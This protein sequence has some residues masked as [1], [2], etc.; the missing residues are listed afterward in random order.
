[1]S[2]TNVYFEWLAKTFAAVTVQQFY[3]KQNM[4]GNDGKQFNHL[5]LLF[6]IIQVGILIKLWAR[7]IY[8][9]IVAVTYKK[10]QR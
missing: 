10:L 6:S 9:E 4:F 2:E 3:Y 8:Q 1:M 5:A 7:I